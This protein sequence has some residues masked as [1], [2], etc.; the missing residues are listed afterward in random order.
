MGQFYALKYFADDL[1]REIRYPI[2][3]VQEAAWKRNLTLERGP[4]SA[5]EADDFY[6]TMRLGELPHST[7]LSCWTGSQLSL[8][9]I[10]CQGRPGHRLHPADRGGYH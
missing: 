2:S 9:H 1:Q 3:E 4:F 5:E 10:F 8:I 6:F 7:C